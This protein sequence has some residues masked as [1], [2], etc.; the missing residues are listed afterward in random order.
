MEENLTIYISESNKGEEQIIINKQYKFNF[1]HIRKDNSRVYKCTEYKKKNKCK[2]FIILNN[3]KEIL[4]YDS[5]HNHPENEYSVSLSIMKHKI[6]YEI[7]KY[8]NP[9]DIKRKSLYNKISKEMRF[10]YPCP[11]YISVKTLISRSIIK[12][13]HP[14]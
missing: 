1:S 5:S 3:E 9:F 14:M 13:Y 7:K 4:K 12:S 8:S 6:K 11:E 10:I 2:S